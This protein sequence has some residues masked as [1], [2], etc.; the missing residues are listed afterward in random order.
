MISHSRSDAFFYSNLYSSALNNILETVFRAHA[1]TGKLQFHAKRKGA[2]ERVEI[3]IP[4]NSEVRGLYFQAA[5]DFRTLDVRQLY[6]DALFSNPP[7]DWRI[8]LLELAVDYGAQIFIGKGGDD[9]V[10]LAVDFILEEQTS[11]C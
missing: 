4:C 9:D 7:L 1:D 11:E 2:V 6:L 5:E 10:K 3:F 8:G